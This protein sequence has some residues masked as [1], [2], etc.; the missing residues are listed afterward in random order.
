MSC[1]V[2]VNA[3]TFLLFSLEILTN[4]APKLAAGACPSTTEDHS[5]DA[6]AGVDFNL[7]ELTALALPLGVRHR[8]HNNVD[9][10]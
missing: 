6:A 2:L 8:D 10:S 9:A 4:P 5:I 1:G 3:K 7:T